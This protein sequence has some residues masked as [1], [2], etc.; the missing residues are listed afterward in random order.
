[1][2]H[3]RIKRLLHGILLRTSL[4]LN[5]IFITVLSILFCALKFPDFRTFQIPAKFAQQCV[6]EKRADTN[7]S[8][9]SLDEAKK[10]NYMRIHTTAIGITGKK[11]SLSFEAETAAPNTQFGQTIFFEMKKKLFRHSVAN[12]LFITHSGVSEWN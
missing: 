11:A 5:E 6:A 4:P 9:K 12:S 3:L 10:L 1:M 7:V 2:S 8:M